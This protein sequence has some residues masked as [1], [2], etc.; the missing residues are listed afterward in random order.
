MMNKKCKN[1]DLLSVTE[2]IFCN[3]PKAKRKK[4][5]S[6][7]FLLRDAKFQVGLQKHFITAE[8][9]YNFKVHKCFLCATTSNTM[10]ES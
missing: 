3:T 5:K 7:G 6:V 9:Y 4:Q 8:I 1:H 2:L 10:N